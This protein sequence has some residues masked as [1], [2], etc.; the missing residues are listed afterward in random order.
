MTTKNPPQLIDAVG[1]TDGWVVTATSGVA[2]FAAPGGGGSS[3]FSA[4]TSGTNTTAT[5]AVGSGAS[6]QYTGTGTII[7]THV[8]VTNEAT[9]TTCFPLFATTATG[10]QTPHS[11][12]ALIFNSNTGA[13]GAT[14]FSGA[15]TGLTGTAASLTAGTASA[16]AVGGITGLGTGV[17]TALA[18][19]VG[20]AGAFV[21]NGGAL[22]TPSSG[23]A[24]NMTGTA[25]GLTA[26]NVTTNANL[27][28]V[29]TSSGNATS[30]ASQ[31]GTGTK[32]VVDTS[33]TLVTPV[34]GVATA[35]S[36]N[37]MAITAPGTS[38]TLAVADGKT[39]TASNTITLTATDGVSA[40]VSSLKKRTIGF[41]T[42]SPVTGQQGS[43]VRFPVAGTITGWSIIADA[44]TATVK[45]WK[46]ASGT[47]APTISN[48]INTSGVALATGT[49][50]ISTTVTD[51]TS[52]TVTANDMFAFDLTAF[53][54]AT[55]IDFQ[56]DISVT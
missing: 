17:S 46:I 4:L 37:K 40:N 7:S 10:D 42:T 30:I 20:T 50:I 32:F 38:S 15:G 2:A 43:Y 3:A 26:G 41:S 16:V 47:T 6:L 35:T 36:V 14:S 48:V 24:T 13:F 55:K 1:I 21:V 12:A 51:F 25:S 29:I 27:T 11:N 18:V 22:G 8:A 23:V 49:A 53:A 33:P 39:F 19:N 44:G 52:T 28:G 34:L 45:V 9:D 31:T 56:L 5:M 54:T